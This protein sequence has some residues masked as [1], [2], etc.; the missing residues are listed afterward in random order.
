M[1]ARAR[2]LGALAPWAALAVLAGA[3]AAAPGPTEAQLRRRV[4]AA[5]R[6]A[7]TAKS[8]AAR[9]VAELRNK[10]DGR[11]VPFYRLDLRIEKARR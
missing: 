9:A 11:L 5:A 3:S 6:E 8:L 7:A 10:A 1:S 2:L 4:E